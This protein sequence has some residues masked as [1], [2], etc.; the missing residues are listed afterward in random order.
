MTER[1]QIQ[2]VNW[3]QIRGPFHSRLPP[4]SVADLVRNTSWFPL[5]VTVPVNCDGYWI[6]KGK[7]HFER[8][9]EM[10]VNPIVFLPF[11]VGERS[12]RG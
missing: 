10:D 8:L 4:E 9:V 6:T 12:L 7:R 2:V 5:I 1:L 3:S 11:R